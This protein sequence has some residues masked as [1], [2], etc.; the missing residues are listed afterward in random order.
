MLDFSDETLTSLLNTKGT[1]QSKK[2]VEVHDCRPHCEEKESWMI[3][4]MANMVAKPAGSL[5]PLCL[6]RKLCMCC[7]SA[8]A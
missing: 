8:G 1:E 6:G 7:L 2:V 4:T 5:H 3:Q